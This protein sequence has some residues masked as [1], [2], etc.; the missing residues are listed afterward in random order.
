LAR[1]DGSEL[2]HL[3]VNTLVVRRDS[4][5]AV[6]YDPI[7]YRISATEKPFA[8]SDLILARKS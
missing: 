4:G 5:V 8:I 6:H 1:A 3:G 2:T 7:M